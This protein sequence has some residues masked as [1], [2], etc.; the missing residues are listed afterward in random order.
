MK[1]AT[2]R[3]MPTEPELA[4]ARRRAYPATEMGR[5]KVTATHPGIRP[6]RLNRRTPA[7]PEVSMMH[8][9]SRRVA[10]YAAAAFGCLAL[11]AAASCGGDAT[12]SAGPARLS[13][14][15]TDAPGDVKAAVVTI[16]EIDLQGSHGST[17]LMNTPVT[18]DLLTLAGTTASLV[19]KAVV[20]P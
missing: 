1:P 10:R 8:L 9:L 15:L 16:S 19:S 12:S 13:V 11:G 2:T 3:T 14:L 17:V 18:T 6:I 5:P 4:M 7:N 20:P